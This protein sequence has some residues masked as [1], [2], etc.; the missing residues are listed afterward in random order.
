[1]KEKVKVLK[2]VI[3][4]E[5]L[6][7]I[8][9]RIPM[10]RGHVCSI[11]LNPTGGKETVITNCN[12]SFHETC[13]RDWIIDQSNC[14]T[15]RSAT[16]W[17]DLTMKTKS[18]KAL[19][20]WKWLVFKMKHVKKRMIDELPDDEIEVN[21]PVSI[22]DP[23]DP[24]IE[25][26]EDDFIQ[27]KLREDLIERPEKTE[28]KITPQMV[29]VKIFY[30]ICDDHSFYTTSRWEILKHDISK[31]NDHDYDVISSDHQYNYTKKQRNKNPDSE[32]PAYR[33]LNPFKSK[34]NNSKD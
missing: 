25:T 26:I 28:T 5:E 14:P 9:F 1:M 12:H 13:L 30:C 19:A 16:K 3:F 7:E 11:C 29:N 17:G 4:Q 20:S 8:N 33:I 24:I 21:K 34:A 27:E 23:D 10:E 31:H 18:S 2:G 22:I 6:R 15:C 32:F